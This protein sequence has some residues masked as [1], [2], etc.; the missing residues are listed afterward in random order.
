MRK[1][2]KISA[3][4][5]TIGL[6]VTSLSAC[7]LKGAIKQ[8]VWEG[9]TFTN[10]WSDIKLTLPENYT[11]LTPDEMSQALSASEEISVNNGANKT[12]IDL[13]NLKTL[14]E[15]M[16]YDDEGVSSLILTYENLA[17]TPLTSGL[18]EEAY[19]VELKKTLDVS[20]MEYAEV[21]KNTVKVAGADYLRIHCSV[22]GG[23][24][25]QDYFLRKHDGAMIAF[26][27]SYIPESEAKM[28][29]FINSLTKASV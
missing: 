6:A 7:S 27:L 1:T 8:G 22:N 29:D 9:S 21:E 14:Y 15:F 12:E 16:I 4:V 26:I 11:S 24:M 18:D 3:I 13:S 28:N 25:F 2:M 10:E 17:L 5:L 23:V 20:G 19:Y